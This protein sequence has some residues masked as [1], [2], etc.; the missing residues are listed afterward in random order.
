MPTTDECK[1]MLSKIGFKL[2]VSPRLISTRLLSDDD[3]QDMLDGNLP[4]EALECAVKVWMDAGMPNY[5]HGDS[6]PYQ[7]K[8]E[9]F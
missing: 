9:G 3:K 7:Q 6:T 1:C 5:A 4:I 8:K 2:G